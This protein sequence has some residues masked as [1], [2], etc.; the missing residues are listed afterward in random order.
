MREMPGVSSR[1]VE[2]SL[3]GARCFQFLGGKGDERLERTRATKIP[4][5][6]RLKH[7]ATSATPRL[8]T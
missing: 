8:L 2:S 1:T 3:P 6:A 7:C 5:H 4:S